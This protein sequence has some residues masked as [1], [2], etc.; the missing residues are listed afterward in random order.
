MI[1]LLAKTTTSN[2]RNSHQIENEAEGRDHATNAETLKKKIA[3][4]IDIHPV[5][6]TLAAIGRAGAEV[7][8]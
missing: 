3:T 1:T 6:A 8:D 4:R 5:L 7:T 2:S